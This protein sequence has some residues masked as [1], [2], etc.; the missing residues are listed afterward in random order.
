MDFSGAFPTFRATRRVYAWIWRRAV[1]PFIRRVVVP[2]I[3]V[4][5]I[6]GAGAYV[7]T[8]ARAGRAL[9]AELQAIRQRG[10]PLTLAEAAPPP[11]PE[12]ENAA[13]LYRRAFERLPRLRSPRQPSPGPRQ[14]AQADELV[15]D[16]I[17]PPYAAR[18]APVSLADL[19]AVLEGTDAALALAREAAAMPRCRF[20]INWED[21]AGALF[22]HL[23]EL[24]TLNRLLAAAAIVAATDGQPARAVADIEAIV[25]TV[26]H[27]SHEPTLISQIV[28][29]ASL[30]TASRALHQTVMASLISPDDCARLQ[31]QL[32]DL[33]LYS[34]FEQALRSERC[35]G[36]WA[37]DLARR[38]PVQFWQ[39]VSS[40][41]ES[42]TEAR[43]LSPFVEPFRKLDERLYLERMDR[44]VRL[45]AQRSQPW[46]AGTDD[47]D[48]PWHGWNWPLYAPISHV[49][50]PAITPAAKKRDEA[51]ARLA[52]LQC[53]LALHVYHQQT[54]RYPASLAAVEKQVGWQLPGDLFTGGDLVYRPHG[55][56]YLLYSVGWNR[57]DEGGAYGKPAGGPPGAPGSSVPPADDI[58]WSVDR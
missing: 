16:R 45:A 36:L 3:C 1:R 6:A 22:P 35:F 50:L 37:F 53:G 7:V 42:H 8:N 13:P 20:P 58:G 34:P 26:G 30:S 48:D 29:Y 12:E 32:T 4:G 51:I 24:R 40:D 10:E 21:G 54:G 31:R 56:G 14:L 55:S 38:D 9:E 18:R 47:M 57:K 28:L 49:M 19:R 46:P 11:V 2:V 25:R 41:P 23:S 39:I 43:V 15:L 17:F 5:G 44:L 33:D 27:M 52:V